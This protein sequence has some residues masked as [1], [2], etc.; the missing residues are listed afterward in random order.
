MPSGFPSHKKKNEN[1]NFLSR[2]EIKLE[3][4]LLF[5]LSCYY[6]TAKIHL[7][8]VIFPAKI[9]FSSHFLTMN[10]LNISDKFCVREQNLLKMRNVVGYHFM[11][12][13]KNNVKILE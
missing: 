11:M 9:N 8:F 10:C 2:Y 13:K 12:E 3:L 7:T 4:L 6:N 5:I 1:R